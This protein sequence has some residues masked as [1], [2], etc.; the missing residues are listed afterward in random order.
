MSSK[1]VAHFLLFKLIFTFICISL[2]KYFLVF[3]RPLSNKKNCY[4]YNYFKR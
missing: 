1:N 3:D 4:E 2:D